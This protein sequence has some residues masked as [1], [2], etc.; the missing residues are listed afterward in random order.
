MI[1]DEKKNFT[2]YYID[3]LVNLYDYKE[4]IISAGKIY[5]TDSK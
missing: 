5:E 3:D 1:P 2:R 4:L